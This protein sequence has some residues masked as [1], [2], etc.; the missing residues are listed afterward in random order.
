[1]S[2][3]HIMIDPGHGGK[4]AGACGNG[5]KEKDITLEVSLAVAKRLRDCG[6]QVSLTRQSDEYVGDAGERGRLI[7]KSGADYGLS[8]HINSSTSSSASGAE[9]LC[10]MKEKYAYTEWALKEELSK[11]GKFRKVTSRDYNSGSFYDRSM[12]NR[13][14]TTSYNKTDYYGVIREAW[15][16]GVS[17]DIVELFF[18]SN[19]SDVANY[20]KQKTAYVE[21]LV[22][23]MCSAFS[24]AY[25][26]PSVSQPAPQPAPSKGKTW[27]R[28]VVGSYEGSQNAQ[29]IKEKLEQAGQT[30]VWFQTVQK[31]GKTYIRVI[32]GSH[33]TKAKAQAV[34]DQLVKQ[35]YTGVWIDAAVI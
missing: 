9:V 26:A 13:M 32:C 1:M 22:K 15:K 23:A 21:A 5:H 28:V 10:P 2:K 34:V 25:V 24:V 11:L 7:G 30:G 35:G 19:A 29:K 27:Y 31:D 14:F 17:A 6:F 33:S 4:D 18:I 16:Y 20:K 12:S 3:K 8:I